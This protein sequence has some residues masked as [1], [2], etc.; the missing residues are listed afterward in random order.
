[1]IV[2]SSYSF[3]K[4]SGTTAYDAN[5]LIANHATAG[6]VV[7]MSFGLKGI[8]GSGIIRGLR[9]FKS[10]TATTQASFKVHLFESAPTPANGDNGAFGIATADGYLDGV[11]V[12]MTSGAQAGTAGLYERI[13]GLAIGF[14]IP[15]INSK[16]YGLL[17]AI[18]TYTPTSS[19][20]FKI[21]LEIE[22]VR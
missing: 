1:M 18:G 3:N 21:T 2:I 12:D 6:S 22:S 8:G 20:T 7:P 19:E 17:Q 13:G 11:A 14:S 4:V 16:L 5:D 15:T 10:G 9:L